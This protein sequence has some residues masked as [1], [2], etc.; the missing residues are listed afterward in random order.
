MNREDLI[1]L[2]KR[3]QVVDGTEEEIDEMMDLFQRNV[4]DPNGMEYIY[5]KEYDGLTAE[6]I[7]DKALD[8]KP[9]IT[10][11]SSNS[12]DGDLES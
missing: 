8:Y 7:V 9:L 12:F 6:E 11:S 3:I 4:I 2:V 5:G 1:K 10:P